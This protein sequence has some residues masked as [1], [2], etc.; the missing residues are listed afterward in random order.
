[1][2]RAAAALIAVLAAGAVAQPPDS[3][4]HYIGASPAACETIDYACPAGWKGFADEHGCGC[5]RP[6]VDGAHGARPRRRQAGHPR[7][8]PPSAPRPE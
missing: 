4:K 7:R 2:N 5:L 3:G 8:H 6:P 1:V